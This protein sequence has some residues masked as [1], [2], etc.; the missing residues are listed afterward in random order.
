MFIHT[1]KC[2]IALF[3]HYCRGG[4]IVASCICHTVHSR[5]QLCGLIYK[6]IV[7]NKLNFYG[8]YIDKIF[9]FILS[10]YKVQINNQKKIN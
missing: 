2:E 10:V 9:F 5:M 8:R 3:I 7:T 1:I 4:Q 6:N